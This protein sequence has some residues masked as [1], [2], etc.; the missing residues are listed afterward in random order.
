[1]IS[2]SPS[3]KKIIILHTTLSKSFI[4]YLWIV[5]FSLTDNNSD[6]NQDDNIR[7][8]VYFTQP[9]TIDINVHIC[10]RINIRMYINILETEIFIIYYTKLR[11]ITNSIFSISIYTLL[12]SYISEILSIII[13]ILPYYQFNFPTPNFPPY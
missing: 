2:T 6:V 1:M 10:I 12:R 4:S 11:N 8:D 13:L 7:W 9:Y 5:H 3:A